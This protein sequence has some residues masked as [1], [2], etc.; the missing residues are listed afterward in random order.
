MADVYYEQNVFPLIKEGKKKFNWVAAFLGFFWFPYKGMWKA[1]A[2]WYVSYAILFPI[3]EQFMGTAG[4]IGIGI[5]FLMSVGSHA[6]KQYYKFYQSK[7][8]S[9]NKGNIGKGIGGVVAYIIILA[10]TYQ[11][12]EAFM[13][14]FR[15]GSVPNLEVI[16]SINVNGQTFGEIIP[17]LVGAVGTYKW[18]KVGNDT[19]LY[20]NKKKGSASVK[21][22]INPNTNYIL[23]TEVVLN[24][25]VCTNQNNLGMQLICLQAITAME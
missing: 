25:E 11:N 14:A 4:I 21:F 23:L 12:I 8:D 9:L 3:I 22:T 15:H 6:N 7:K 16:E 17:E 13:K 10:L 18:K 1:W 19:I 5:G 24:N 2:Q 20:I